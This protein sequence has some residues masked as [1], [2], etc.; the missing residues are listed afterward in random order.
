MGIRNVGRVAASTA[1]TARTPQPMGISAELADARQQLRAV[2]PAVPW[3][4]VEA[5]VKRA[6]AEQSIT[7]LQALQWVYAEAA[8]GWWPPRRRR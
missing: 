5:E 4:A 7:R 3:D 6:Q 1:S 8:A 2:L